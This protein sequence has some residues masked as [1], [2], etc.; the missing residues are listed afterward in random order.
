MS[1][2]A[3]PGRSPLPL[4]AARPALLLPGTECVAARTQACACVPARRRRSQRAPAQEQGVPQPPQLPVQ[5]S[6]GR[7]LVS[8]CAGRAQSGTRGEGRWGEQRTGRR[9][10]CGS[11]GAGERRAGAQ[12]RAPMRRERDPAAASSAPPLPPWAMR[13]ARCT[14][15]SRA[16]ASPAGVMGSGQCTCSPIPRRPRCAANRPFISALT[17]EC[18]ASTLRPQRCMSWRPPRWLGG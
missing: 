15:R 17:R 4:R 2:A 5:Q 13:A 7:L 11:V 14:Q 12:V 1:T 6:L 10:C 8:G 16:P 18:A 9:R 3:A